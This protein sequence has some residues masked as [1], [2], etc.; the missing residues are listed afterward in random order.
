MIVPLNP[1]GSK[2]RLRA[3]AASAPRRL[4]DSPAGLGACGPGETSMGRAIVTVVAVAW[5]SGPLGAG[6]KGGVAIPDKNLEAA[7]RGYLFEA[8]GELTEAMLANL[9]VLEAKGK[10][11]ANLAGLEKCKNL[12]LINLA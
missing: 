11:I 1:A 5:A 12:A 8:K 3:W 6:G 2:A 4:E 7:L 10:K 9:S